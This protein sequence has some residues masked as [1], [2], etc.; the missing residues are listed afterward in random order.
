MT[1]VAKVGKT[2]RSSRKMG[3]GVARNK[4]ISRT[5]TTAE[6]IQRTIQGRL[7]NEGAYEENA[8][9]HQDDIEGSVDGEEEERGDI[10]IDGEEAPI[11]QGKSHFELF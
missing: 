5:S 9:L 11:A 4:S 8:P 2:A 1:K 7:G 6:P 10:G 3:K